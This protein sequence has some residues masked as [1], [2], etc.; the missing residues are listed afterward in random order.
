MKSHMMKKI[1]A[2]TLETVTKK[3]VNS[4]G[5]FVWYQPIEP[6]SL[7]KYKCKKEK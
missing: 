7:E 2:T 1:I 4:S 3:T 6:K 5:C